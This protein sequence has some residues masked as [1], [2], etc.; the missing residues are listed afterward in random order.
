MGVGNRTEPCTPILA[1]IPVLVGEKPAD[2]AAATA[3][4]PIGGLYADSV[5]QALYVRLA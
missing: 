5:T 2:A 1:P 4:V 3:G